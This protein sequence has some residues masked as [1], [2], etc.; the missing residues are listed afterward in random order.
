MTWEYSGDPTTSAKDE[1]RF[2]IGDTDEADQLVQDEEIDYLVTTFGD[3]T[4]SAAYA[5]QALSAKY[6]RKVD[7]FVG[8]L[9]IY[10]SQK[11]AN[12]QAQADRLFTAAGGSATP[13]PAVL[14]Y[15]GGLSVAEKIEHDMDNDLIQ[16]N[17]YVGMDDVDNDYWNRRRRRINNPDYGTLGS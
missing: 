12:F 8:D 9:R 13:V 7:K 2:L 1:V 6:A 14:P 10:M 3:A 15:A 11:A 17:F 5:C 4:L 16:S